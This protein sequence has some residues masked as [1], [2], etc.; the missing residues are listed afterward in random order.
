MCTQ[1]PPNDRVFHR[2]L[3]GAAFLLALAFFLLPP[4]LDGSLDDIP[5]GGDLKD[6]DNLAFSLSQG[7]GFGY[8][9]GDP[10]WREVYVRD[11]ENGRWDNFLANSAERS[12]ELTT[13]RPPVF[14]MVLAGIYKVAGRD[15]RVWRAL[16]ACLVALAVAIAAGLSFRLAGP[17]TTTIVAV[18]AVL[19][20]ELVSA[21]TDYMTEGLAIFGV[22]MLVVLLLRFA[23]K[24]RPK[25][26]AL[27][28]FC[29]GALLLTRNLFI[30]WYLPV[31][32]LM[33]WLAH[34]DGAPI[35]PFRTARFLPIAAFLA[36]ALVVPTPWWVR[37]CVLLEEF[38]PLG[39]QGGINLP[40]GFSDHAFEHDGVWTDDTPY[41]ASFV[42]ELEGLDTLGKERALAKIGS[43][44]A[45]EWVLSHPIE[46][47][48]LTATKLRLSLREDVQAHWL[49]LMFALIGLVMLPRNAGVILASML[50]MNLLPVIMT[51]KGSDNR[52]MIP[53]R[54]LVYVSAAA[55]AGALIVTFKDHFSPLRDGV[56]A[57]ERINPL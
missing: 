9:F 4:T 19:D 57:I 20:E 33:V 8:H 34:R 53:V 45:R 21:S 39:T 26:A 50:L 24:R 55:G 41:F 32:L 28:G 52:V 2:L 11:N 7:K 36:A 1:T 46:A 37:N 18:L 10:E 38:S 23:G 16:E 22:I 25:D 44:I 12:F 5:A 31:L 27:A 3:L 48:Q 14:P 43:R 17:A 56:P 35:R 42:P 51:Y 13:Y 15:F 6:Y 40:H 54:L 49:A 30:L 29:L 47:L